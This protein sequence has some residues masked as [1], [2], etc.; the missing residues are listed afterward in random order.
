MATL[1][2]W[3]NLAQADK[4]YFVVDNSAAAVPVTVPNLPFLKVAGSSRRAFPAADNIMILQYGLKM[5]ECFDWT[6]RDG[7]ALPDFTLGWA[8]ASDSTN[9]TTLAD[10]FMVPYAD[11]PIDLKGSQA[12]GFYL[13]HYS[14]L[15]PD[16][17]VAGKLLWRMSGL[18]IS[19]AGV[20][21]SLNGIT[22][23]LD[24]FVKVQHQIA[25]Q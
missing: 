24:P 4:P 3:M 5:P 25:I 17:G 7:D 12:D 8:K 20:P 22:M 6:Q 13:Q 18:N 9:L 21:D 10:P 11:Q 1:I 19:M 14:I 16:P 15:Y 23:Y 2:S